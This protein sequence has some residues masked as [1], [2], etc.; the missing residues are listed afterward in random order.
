LQ[1]AKAG[2]AATLSQQENNNSV[3]V[4]RGVFITRG[5]VPSKSSSCWPISATAYAF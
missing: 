1:F 4:Q 3:D 2:S 5:D